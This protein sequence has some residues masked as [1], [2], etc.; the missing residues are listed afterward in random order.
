MSIVYYTHAFEAS[1]ETERWDLFF[2]KL[3]DQCPLTF[4]EQSWDDLK[5]GSQA[6]LVIV[7]GGDGSL[8][9]AVTKICENQ[10]FDKSRYTSL[11]KCI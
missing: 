11:R 8:N 6:G 2:E 10:R 7:S 5:T 3:G 9:G 4:K 1:G